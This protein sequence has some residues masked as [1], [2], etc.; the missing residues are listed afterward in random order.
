MMA[1]QHRVLMCAP[2]FFTVDYAI[3]PW[4]VAGEGA[5]ST[6][7][8][9]TQWKTLHDALVEVAEVALLPPVDGLPDM[10]FT[11]NAGVVYGK[12]AI[13]SRFEFDERRGEEVHFRRWFENHGFEI[14]DWPEDLIFE[15]AGDALVDRGGP[16][17]WAGYGQRTEQA[18]HEELAKFYPD[19]EL[20]SM[21]LVDPRFYHIDTCLQP[22]EGGYLLYYPAAFDDTGRAEIERRVPA[23]KRIAVSTE[24]AGA[25]ACN[26]IN[27]DNHIALNRPSSRL[28]GALES[29][30]FRVTGLDLSEFLKSG[31]SSKCLVLRLDEP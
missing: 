24:E 22:L 23:D 13:V 1:S 30:G 17:V 20:I 29:A 28:Q 11:A 26:A 16:R 6:R 5:V 18:A 7:L 31:G 27:L 8:A 4:M 10:V 9:M 2:D 21:R 14:V 3:N 19:R 25:F 15:G 12:R